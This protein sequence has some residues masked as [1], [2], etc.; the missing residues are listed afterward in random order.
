MAF[1]HTMAILAI[2][3][4]SVAVQ[5]QPVNVSTSKQNAAKPYRIQTSGKQITIKST[6][7]I[8][9]IIIW[10]S[11]GHRIAENRDVRN[12]NYSFRI[13][14]REKIFFLRLQ[15]VDGKTYSEKIGVE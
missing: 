2:S 15:L 6:K 9:S 11:D 8:K 14:V 1:A 4:L 3:L 10:T 13:T 7:D 12:S 5:A